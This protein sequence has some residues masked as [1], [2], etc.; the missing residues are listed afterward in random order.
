ME[1]VAMKTKLMPAKKSLVIHCH[2][3][4]NAA[5][6]SAVA[7]AVVVAVEMTQFVFD[8]SR[9]GMQISV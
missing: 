6:E 2:L 9:S 8:L 1:W 4:E 7:V 3:P 5:A